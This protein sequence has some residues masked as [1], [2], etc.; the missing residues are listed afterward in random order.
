[1]T[2]AP[3]RPCRHP[4]CSALVERGE[5]TYCAAHRRTAPATVNRQLSDRHRGSAAARGY[6]AD[7]QRARFAFLSRYPLC[8]GVL[9][10]TADWTIELAIAFH[11]QREAEHAAGRLLI[12]GSSLTTSHLPLVAWLEA[13]PIYR[14]ERWDVSRP[15]TV[16]DH[17]VPHK[18]DHLL[19]WAEWNWQPLTKRA[20]DRKTATE[21]A[22]GLQE[23]RHVL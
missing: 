12:F 14:L 11:H 4:G 15:A 7:W 2:S 20:H 5:G 18:G 23:E 16:V 22:R 13:N 6:D 1:M 17:I 10:P 19:M 9:L 3:K 8:P 21:Q